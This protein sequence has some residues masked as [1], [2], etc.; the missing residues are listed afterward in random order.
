MLHGRSAETAPIDVLLAAARHG[1]SVALV[2]RDEAGVGKPP[3]AG[4]G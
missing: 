3:A 2:I 4:A 1:R